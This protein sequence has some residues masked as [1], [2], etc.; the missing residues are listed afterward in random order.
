MLTTKEFMDDAERST[1][2]MM[3]SSVFILL[4]I[5]RS[6]WDGLIYAAFC[7]HILQYT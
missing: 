2:T 7:I 3:I 1:E 6:R 5:E 4:F